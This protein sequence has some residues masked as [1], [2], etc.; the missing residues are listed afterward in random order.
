MAQDN[1]RQ[2][3]RIDCD[4]PI[5]LEGPEG[6]VEARIVDLSRVGLR[7]RVPGALLG[8]HRL[9]SLVQ[10]T[11][12][13]QGRLGRSFPG[14]LHHEMLGP[15]VSRELSPCR[16]AK[17]DWE[18]TDV[19]VGCSFDQPLSEEETLMLGVPLPPLH[20]D[21]GPEEGRDRPR[22]PH[23]VRSD[24]AAYVAYLYPAPGKSAPPLVTTTRSL[25]R[26]MAILDVDRRQGWDRP[27]LGV[28]EVIVALDEAYGAAVLLRIVDGDD[29]LWAGPA[30]VQEVDVL[31]ETADIRIGAA[32]GRELRT[33]ELGRL[34]LP[35][36][37]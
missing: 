2:A 35:T 31:P 18:H 9:S 4:I 12:A 15:L 6:D 27:D 14:V 34:G 17:R 23:L 5:R 3:A 28:S 33:E 7:V 16:I 1:R 25:T 37:A 32:F 11:R 13:L 21:P 22:G 10:V 19:E 24:P 20:A 29:D 36:P 26:G 8:V 30:E